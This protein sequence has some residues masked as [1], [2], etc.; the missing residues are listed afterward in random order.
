MENTGYKSFAKLELYYT[1]DNSPTGQPKD[2]LITD[3]DYIAP[4]KDTMFCP[5]S[6]RYYSE[7]KEITV[8]KNNCT[9]GQTGSTV[10]FI[11]DINMFISNNDIADANAKRDLWLNENAQI[12]ANNKGVCELPNT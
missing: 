6:D 11:A 8:T 5:P 9:D 7:R 10:T 1:D 12:Y 2:N 4:I 3:P